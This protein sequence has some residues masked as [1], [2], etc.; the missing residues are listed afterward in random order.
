MMKAATRNAMRAHAIAEYPREC[1][2]FVV[3]DHTGQELYMPGENLAPDPE[4][5]FV[6]APQAWA[7]AEDAGRVVAFVH[8]H[9][10][11]S[12]EPSDADRVSAERLAEQYEP[13]PWVILEVRRDLDGVVSVPAVLSFTP[14]GYRAPLV[15]RTFEHGILDCYTLVRD[16]YQRE[17]G[18][19]LPDFERADGWW[20]GDRELYLE[21]FAAA[22][23][24]RMPDGAPPKRGDVILMQ[25]LSARTNHAG[26]FLGDEG[27][28]EEPAL[29]VVKGAMLHHLYGRLSE[30]VLYGGY[31]RD[32]T[33]AILRHREI[34]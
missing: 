17:L 18:I 19:V 15:G 8:S 10:E 32:C 11:G 20:N 33:R 34:L 6:T 3:V 31:W 22:G 2:G 29:F 13:I 25:H 4:A 1:V 26:V 24:V 16:F 14:D 12:A 9:P 27:L 21:N 28:A 23:F 7:D 5:G 30:R